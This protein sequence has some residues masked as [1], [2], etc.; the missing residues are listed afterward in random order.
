VH[1]I[2]NRGACVVLSFDR[3]SVCVSHREQTLESSRSDAD[4]RAEDDLVLLLVLERDRILVKV[5]RPALGVRLNETGNARGPK[6]LQPIRKQPLF[7]FRW[8]IG[9]LRIDVESRLHAE[10]ECDQSREW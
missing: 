7:L 1:P 8:G 6:P 4:E 9:P 10:E 2:E 3:T 5:E